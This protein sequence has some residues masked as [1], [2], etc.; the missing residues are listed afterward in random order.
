MMR[1][2]CHSFR[3]NEVRLWLRLIDSDLGNLPRLGL[4]R[5]TDNWTLTTL[6]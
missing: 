1:L 5:R 3:L 2:S 4:P 6:Q